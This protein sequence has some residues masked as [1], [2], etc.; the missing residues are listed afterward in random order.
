VFT[1]NTKNHRDK[2]VSVNP[3]G[4][5]VS[6][7]WQPYVRNSAHEAERAS[8]LLTA[9]C[10]VPVPVRGVVVVLAER[11][12]V[13]RRPDE[14][15]V[16]RSTELKPWLKQ[17]PAVLDAQTVAAVYAQARWQETWKP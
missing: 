1:L 17:R 4:V 8:R 10:G 13:K 9:A 14:V 2:R 16:L 3:R 11:F 6:G 7:H 5:F 12:S 15:T